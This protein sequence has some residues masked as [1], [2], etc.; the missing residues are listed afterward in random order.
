MIKQY[1]I[2]WAN[3][4][5]QKSSIQGGA[6]PVCIIS[7]DKCNLHSPVLT[8]VPITSKHKNHLCTHV[9]CAIENHIDTLLCEQIMSIDK[10]L[11]S[12]RIGNVHY[13]SK[14]IQKAIKIQLG[15]E[16]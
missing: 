10:G 5:Y 14:E 12:T 8:V 13:K 9:N 3:L 11:L 4:P 2:W 7:N 1:D 6:R 16:E 15:M